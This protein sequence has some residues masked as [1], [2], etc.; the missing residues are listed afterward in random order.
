MRMI[1]TGKFDPFSPF[2]EDLSLRGRPN[3]K[4]LELFPLARMLHGW[5]EAHHHIGGGHGIS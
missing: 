5:F 4:S 1:G 2:G 3:E